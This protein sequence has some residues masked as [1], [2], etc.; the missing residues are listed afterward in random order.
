MR[1]LCKKCFDKEGECG[2]EID[3]NRKDYYP[4]ADKERK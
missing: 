4:V 1:T 3:C 2:K